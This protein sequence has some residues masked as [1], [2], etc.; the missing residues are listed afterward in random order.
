MGR[1]V[2]QCAPWS[3]LETIKTA[4]RSSLSG[5][6]TVAEYTQTF[7]PATS[8]TGSASFLPGVSISVRALDHV[9]PP[10]EESEPTI[11]IFL[12]CLPEHVQTQSN[13]PPFRR[14]IEGM[15]F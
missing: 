3:S 14:A 6:F 10:S 4:L 12:S 11:R 9:L 5:I 7:D 15:A 8:S 2:D 13:F 1:G